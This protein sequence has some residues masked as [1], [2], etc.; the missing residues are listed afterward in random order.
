[1]GHHVG[2]SASSRGRSSSRQLDG[3]AY[4]LYPRRYLRRMHVPPLGAPSAR[5]HCRCGILS[6]F[7]SPI[8]DVGMLLRRSRGDAAFADFLSC[9][10]YARTASHSGSMHSKSTGR[11]P[12]KSFDGLGGTESGIGEQALQL[13]VSA[14]ALVRCTSLRF[15]GSIDFVLVHVSVSI[16]A[17]LEHRRPIAN[18]TWRKAKSSRTSSATTPSSRLAWFRVT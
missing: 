13:R 17:S 1:M 10:F 7:S 15:A 6:S 14:L 4:E 16:A 12:E 5:E 9:R 8:G 18:G 11:A 2:V 3:V